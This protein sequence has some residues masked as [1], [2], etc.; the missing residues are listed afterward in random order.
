MFYVLQC[1]PLKD[2]CGSG[3]RPLAEREAIL[4]DAACLYKKVAHYGVDSEKSPKDP[5]ESC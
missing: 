3:A 2:C 5:F 4:Q 1:D